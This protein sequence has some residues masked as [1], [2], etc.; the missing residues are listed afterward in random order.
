[1]KK[2]RWWPLRDLIRHIYSARAWYSY[3][4]MREFWKQEWRGLSAS[5]HSDASFSAAAAAGRVTSCKTTSHKNAGRCEAWVQ[6]NVVVMITTVVR[7][8][9]STVKPKFH[10][11]DFPVTSATSPRKTCDVPLA[12]IPL[13]R[14][15]WNFPVRESRRNGIR[16]RGDV[17]HGFVAD[18]TGKTV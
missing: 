18:V 5:Y 17:D 14:L 11:T 2:C 8:W 9:L 4:E 6:I 15:P 12:R 7:R 16:A 3:P 13:R 10:Y 1:M